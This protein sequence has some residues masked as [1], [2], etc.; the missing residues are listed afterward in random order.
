MQQGSDQVKRGGFVRIATYAL[1][2]LAAIFPFTYYNSFLYWGTS[3]RSVL[4]ILLTTLVGVAF[5]V[6]LFRKDTVFSI[7]KSPVLLALVLYFISLTISGIFGLSFENT[8]WSAIARTTGLWYFIHLGLLVFFLAKLCLDRTI[9]RKLILTVVVSTALYSFMA[10]LSPEGIGILFIGF[11]TDAFTFGNSTFAAMYLFG[12]FLLSIYYIV[13]S[14]A[15]KWWMF[16]FPIVILL[17]PEIISPH[18]WAGTLAGLPIGDAK[19]TTYVILLSVVCLFFIWLISKI[20]DIKK[21]SIT[22]YSIFGLACIGIVFFAVSLFSSNGYVR[23]AYLSQSTAARPL[24]WEISQK[25]ISE[26]PFFGW[27]ADNFE[28]VFEVMYDNRFLQNEYGNEPWFDRAHNVFIDQAVD[29]GVIGLVIYIGGFITVI[30]CLIY[31]AL[32]S[33]DKKDRVLASV[34]IVYFSLHLLELQTAFDTSIS[35]VM[36]AIM[37]ALAASVYHRTLAQVKGEEPLWTLRSRATRI[38]L[39]CVMLVFFVWSFFW[40]L[41]PLVR[42]Q[43]TNGTIRTVGNSERRLPLYQTL[44]AS[45]VDKHAFLWRTITDFQRGIGQNPE[46]LTK[47]ERVKGLKA[48]AELFTKLY[49]EYVETHPTHYRAHLNLADILIYQRLFGINRLEEAQKVLD[50]AIG[51]VPQAPQAYWMKAVAYLYMG[52]F[53]SA[54]EYAQKALNLN[55]KIKQSQDITEYIERS[56]RTF[57]E[58][59][60]YFFKYI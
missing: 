18:L 32:R 16:V 52:K 53:A 37:L 30:L 23:Q 19:A 54:S 10:F 33:L 45:P 57:P 15:K 20:R 12:S 4:L 34:L 29:N 48:E 36:L 8:F 55:P 9:Q 26:R 60:L 40:G 11:N 44:F 17:S 21:R 38:V 35:Y 1:Y 56:I 27:G 14:D 49:G 42:A 28:R 13:Q 7:Q 3:T 31:S 46:V 6:S 5:A 22:A 51:L 59:D 50:D 25:A 39:A 47:P 43:I 2:T 24:L 58:V 41:V